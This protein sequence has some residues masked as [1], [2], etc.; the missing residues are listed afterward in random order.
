MA[1]V[2]PIVDRA[3]SD[4][5]GRTSKG[6]FNVADWE[7]IDGNTAV[8]KAMLDTAGYLNIPLLHLLRRQ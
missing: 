6:F 4:I 2:T 7:R 5:T 8:I 1:W 3:L